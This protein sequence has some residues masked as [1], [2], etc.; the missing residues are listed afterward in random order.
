M[1]AVGLA[2]LG[3]TL[4]APAMAQWAQGGYVGGSIGATQSRFDNAPATTPPTALTATSE[5]DSEIGGKLFLG[6]QFH[7]NFAVEAGVFHLGS[8]DYA[9]GG[10]AG[11]ISGTSRYRGLNLDLVGTLPITDRFSGIARIGAAWTQ[12]R[13][14]V[15]TTGGIVGGGS[16][17]DRNW[18][19]KI[20]I[21]IEY[22][23]TPTLAMRAEI[24]R[25]RVEDAARGRDYVDM[26]SIGLVYRFGAP[27][28]TMTRVVAPPPQPAPAPAPR[29]VM[30]PPPP[31]PAVQPPPPPPPPAPAP[32]PLPARPYRN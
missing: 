25:Y 15:T 18:G 3:A 13:S 14:S 24:E 9:F 8:F 27:A 20:G 16:G 31:A 12:S 23:F 4:G 28:P 32:A 21:G 1:H 22:A 6:Y 2:V 30:P 26:A 10:P 11:T 19:P 5:D 7:R 17:S 29:A